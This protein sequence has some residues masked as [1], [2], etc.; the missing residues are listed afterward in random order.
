MQ[1]IVMNTNKIRFMWQ[2]SE[3]GSQMAVKKSYLSN[4]KILKYQIWNI[5]Y[6]TS[7]IKFV[8]SKK[9]LLE[10]FFNI[11]LCI[12]C[13]KNG[14]FVRVYWS[15]FSLTL[16]LNIREITVQFC[17]KILVFWNI[18][19][20]SFPLLDS[21]FLGSQKTLIFCCLA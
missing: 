4:W 21:S 16:I 12:M 14:I 13:S 18:Y 17:G 1:P 19:D 11:L 6:E 8:C 9:G 15:K 10:V 7:C 20:F 2:Q 3:N 5:K